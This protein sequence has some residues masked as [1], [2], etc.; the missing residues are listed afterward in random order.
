[1]VTLD[2]LVVTPA[3]GIWTGV[4]ALGAGRFLAIWLGGEKEDA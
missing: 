4:S 3:L 2:N 1:M